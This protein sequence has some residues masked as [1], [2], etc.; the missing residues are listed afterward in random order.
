ME[1]AAGGRAIMVVGNGE[2]PAGAADRIDSADVVIRFNDCRSIGRGGWKTDIVAVCNTGRPALAMLGGGQWKGHPAVRAAGAFW[3]VRDPV[4]YAAMRPILARSNPDLEDFC[5]DYTLGFKTF[6]TASGRRCYVVPASVHE[7][8]D[9]ELHALATSPYVVPSSGLVVVAEV[10]ENLVRR[11][12]RVILAG[13]GHSGWEWHPFAAERAWVDR[14]VG[15]GM[16]ERLSF[17]RDS[18]PEKSH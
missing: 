5:D 6:A 3:C 15:A 17:P 1:T 2:L 8:L 13:F 18:N 16:L 10:L 7:A 12:D 11:N 14:L 4:K 9:D